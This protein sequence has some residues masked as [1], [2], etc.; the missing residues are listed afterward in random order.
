MATFK[1]CKLRV[2]FGK[3]ELHPPPTLHFPFHEKLHLAI[4]P[5]CLGGNV[6]E[7]HT[8]LQRCLS[9][10]GYPSQP[11]PE[12]RTTLIDSYVESYFPEFTAY[13]DAAWMRLPQT[14][15]GLHTQPAKLSPSNLCYCPQFF[16]L[17]LGAGGWPLKFHFAT[18]DLWGTEPHGEFAANGTASDAAVQVCMWWK[19]Y[20][21]TD[22]MVFRF[23]DWGLHR[24][25]AASLRWVAAASVVLGLLGVLGFSARPTALPVRLVGRGGGTYSALRVSQ[26]CR[27][28]LENWRMT[29]QISIFGAT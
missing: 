3:I 22:P 11:F 8:A 16:L 29:W 15:P 25:V 28:I 27:S 10:W 4:S 5:Q 9:F 12:R 14:S 26:A 18:C 6:T 13:R 2:L 7:Q 19:F 17:E 24:H 1:D 23:Q 21:C 20:L